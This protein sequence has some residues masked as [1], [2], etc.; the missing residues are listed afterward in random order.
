MRSAGTW[1]VFFTGVTSAR[2]VVV[3]RNPFARTW[4]TQ[5]RQQPQVGVLYTV[6]R[7]LSIWRAAAVCAAGGAFVLAAGAGD[8]AESPRAVSSPEVAHAATV[9]SASA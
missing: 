1:W 6:M 4:S 9:S 3:A 8:V 2:S 5:L 7:R